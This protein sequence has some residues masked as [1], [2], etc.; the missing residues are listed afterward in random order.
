MEHIKYVIINE[1]YPVIFFAGIPH[2]AMSK[3]GKVTSAGFVKFYVNS[4]CE[5]SVIVSGK[6]ESLG[7]ESDP[8]DA[9]IIKRLLNL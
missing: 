2:K 3:V 9:K 7:I 1:V 5:I 8:E 6:S 4:D